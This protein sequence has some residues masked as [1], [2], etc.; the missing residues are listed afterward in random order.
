MFTVLHNTSCIMYYLFCTDVRDEA[1][2]SLLHLACEGGHKYVVECLV[3]KA[4]CDV[5]E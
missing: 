2:R 5:S 4:N 1:N 3:E